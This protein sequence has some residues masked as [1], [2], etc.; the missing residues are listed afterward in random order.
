[1]L[2]KAHFSLNELFSKS[3]II[4]EIIPRET[5]LTDLEKGKIIVKRENGSSMRKIARSE[6]CVRH[7][8][9]SLNTRPKN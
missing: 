1:M 4:I 6:S 3:I 9:H 8:I 2:R 7:Y 5:L